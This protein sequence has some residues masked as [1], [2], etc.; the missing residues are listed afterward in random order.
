MQQQSKRTEMTKIHD[1]S[2]PTNTN[3]ALGYSDTEFNQIN[4]VCTLSNY[5]LCALFDLCKH[6]CLSQSIEMYYHQIYNKDLLPS[7]PSTSFINCSISACSFWFSSKEI[8]GST[9]SHHALAKEAKE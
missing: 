8:S 1:Y 7:F 5:M 4:A 6:H 2:M 9:L 3:H